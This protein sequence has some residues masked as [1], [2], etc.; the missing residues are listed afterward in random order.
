M[1]PADARAAN[2]W[3]AEQTRASKTVSLD[4]LQREDDWAMTICT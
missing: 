1:S 3:Y 4:Q 2:C